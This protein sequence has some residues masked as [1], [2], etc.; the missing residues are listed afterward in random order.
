MGRPGLAVASRGRAGV[1]LGGA[2]EAAGAGRFLAKEGR[3]DSRGPVG[4][5][6]QSTPAKTS[7]KAP[8]QASR[9]QNPSGSQDQRGA[10]AERAW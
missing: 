9:G 6:V 4:N 2:V 8:P 3:P 10:T 1:A 5:R 7:P